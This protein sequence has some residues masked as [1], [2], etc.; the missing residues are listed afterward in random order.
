MTPPATVLR[1]HSYYHPSLHHDDSR[2]GGNNTTETYIQ[3]QNNPDPEKFP[4]SPVL[5]TRAASQSTRARRER[6]F[7]VDKHNRTVLAPTLLQTKKRTRRCRVDS[8]GYFPGVKF[9]LT[10]VSETSVVSIIKGANDSTLH[11]QHG[12]SLKT[13]VLDV[14]FP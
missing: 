14:L 8:F 7:R 11:S 4:K 1:L 12:E 2:A 13:T 5:H 6:C 3:N 10:D 9:L